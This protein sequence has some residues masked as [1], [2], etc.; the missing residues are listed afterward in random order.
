MKAIGFII[1]AGIVI[2]IAWM[3]ITQ[4]IMPAIRGTFL[5]PAFRNE[6]KLKA[7]IF[8]AQTAQREA[9]LAN[10]IESV[11]RRNAQAERVWGA[12]ATNVK[13]FEDT[14]NEAGLETPAEV[15]VELPV[16]AK[17]EPVVQ[18]DFNGPPHAEVTFGL[19]AQQ[20]NVFAWNRLHTSHPTK[21]EADAMASALNN[22][23]TTKS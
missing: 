3:L 7:K 9:E 17:P 12:H 11:G 5:F 21:E 2:L 6:A 20:W 10:E 4:I 18:P 14:L 16:Q 22:Q 13:A 19:V 1:E 23:G 15:D 8:Q